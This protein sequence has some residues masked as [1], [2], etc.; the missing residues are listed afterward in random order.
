VP[1]AGLFGGVFFAIGLWPLHAALTSWPV[2][3]MTGLVFVAAIG[4]FAYRAH[5]LLIPKA[6]RKSPRAWLEERRTARQAELAAFPI[7]SMEEV[8]ATPAAQAAAASNR[9]QMRRLAPFLLIVGIAAIGLSVHLGRQLAHRESVGLR[10]AGTVVSLVESSGSDGSTYYPVVRFHDA[11]ESEVRFKDNFGS[12]P[13]SYRV[14]DSV[15]VLYERGSSA[16]SA[17]IDRG[18]W[19]WLPTA[20]LAL[21]G[22]VL[23]FAG[24][25]LITR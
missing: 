6:Q 16:H 10:A 24:S 19:N 17:M 9:R 8:L 15:T 12:Y 1:I 18:S 14:G 2:T 13:A 22:A 11:D 7:R 4:Y 3:P 25:R 5:G 21:F 23:T 20:L